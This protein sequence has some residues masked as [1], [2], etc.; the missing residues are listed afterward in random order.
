MSME[1]LYKKKVSEIELSIVNSLIECM[2]PKYIACRESEVIQPTEF[3]LNRH[4]F[5]KR[6]CDYSELLEEEKQE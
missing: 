3:E 1:E 6:L 5:Y 4:D 2:R